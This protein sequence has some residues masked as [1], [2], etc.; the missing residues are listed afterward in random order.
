MEEINVLL[1]YKYVKIK[2]PDSFSQQHLKVLKDL[3]LKGRVL[4]A[5][6]GING[7]VSGSIESTEKYKR[8]THSIP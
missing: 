8:Y 1:F 6:E 4:V 3:N 7:G 2:N 5:E